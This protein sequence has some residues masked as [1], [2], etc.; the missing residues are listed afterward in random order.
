MAAFVVRSYRS[1]LGRSV[2]ANVDG[3]F[4]LDRVLS[5]CVRVVAMSGTSVV[6][7]QVPCIRYWDQCHNS[8][9]GPPL[10]GLLL[11]QGWRGMPHFET[12]VGSE[13]NGSYLFESGNSH[14]LSDMS[15]RG[16]SSRDASAVFNC[17]S[18]DVRVLQDREDIVRVLE[19]Y[20]QEPMVSWGGVL[21]EN[22]AMIMSLLSLGRWRTFYCKEAS[23]KMVCASA[24]IDIYT[25]HS[26]DGGFG[27]DLYHSGS[28]TDPRLWYTSSARLISY[29]YRFP[30]SLSRM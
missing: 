15:V 6:L 7:Y 25:Q 4:G 13:D 12:I 10:L 21:K 26:R 22:C 2:D 16:L 9:V 8:V 28:V 14:K 20:F 11:D 17:L 1:V 18:R 27:W 5:L 24:G 29:Q 19:A 30:A 23:V 3:S